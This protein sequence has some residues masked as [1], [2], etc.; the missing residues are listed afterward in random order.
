[1]V[2]S[3]F[4]S[5]YLITGIRTDSHKK[6]S[7]NT[8]GFAD[9]QVF[10]LFPPSYLSLLCTLFLSS[11]STPPTKGLLKWLRAMHILARSSQNILCKWISKGSP[12]PSIVCKQILS[13]TKYQL[14]TNISQIDCTSKTEV[15]I[16][17]VIC[18]LC[19]VCEKSFKSHKMLKKLC[20]DLPNFFTWYKQ[21]LFS[22]VILNW[23]IR[24]ANMAKQNMC[25]VFAYYFTHKYRKPM[26]SDCKS[27]T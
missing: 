13:A 7:W 3:T 5:S 26:L 1:M 22:A 20:Y 12:F 17:C 25:L 4:C 16:H 27:N 8:L 2:K 19:L 10:F 21:E 18:I 6:G 15:E 23:L 14:L 9:L 24:L 11:V